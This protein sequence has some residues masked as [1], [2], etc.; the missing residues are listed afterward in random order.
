MPIGEY[1]SGSGLI[2]AELE[3]SDGR[4]EYIRFT[5]DFFIF[6]EEKLEKLE[7]LLEGERIER[8]DLSD[9]IEEFY[10]DDVETPGMVSEDWLKA[11][12]RAMEE[13]E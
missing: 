1:K 11:V 3:I 9:K 4:I 12:L 7:S 5:G 10:E 13:K 8:E 2:R 6:P